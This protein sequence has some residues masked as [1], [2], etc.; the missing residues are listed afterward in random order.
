MLPFP[1]SDNLIFLKGADG[2][3]DW[4]V[5]DQRDKAFTDNPLYP[6]FKID[7]LP[8]VFRTSRVAAHLYFGKGEWRERLEHEAETRHYAEG[9]R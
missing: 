2:T 8:R 3:F 1:G 4:V 5:R 6:V 7:E 9:G